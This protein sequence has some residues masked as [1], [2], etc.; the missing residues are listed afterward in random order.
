MNATPHVAQNTNG[1]VGDRRPHHAARGLCRE[2]THP[3]TDR[4]GLRLD[5]DHRR[6]GTDQ[7]PAAASASD[8]PSPSPPPLTIWPGCRSSWRRWREGPGKLPP[9]RPLADRRGRHLGPGSPRSLRPGGAD[10]HRARRR[11]RLRRLGGRPRSRIRPRLD[12]LS[13]GRL[14]RK[15][16]RSMAKEPPNFSTTAPSRS[17]SNTETATKPSS[18]R[19]G[20][21]LQ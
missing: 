16:T 17:N 20:T 21:L 5:Q 2:P 13:L 4:G 10:N 19:N 18:K 14:A 1:V 11:N 3:Q 9:D 7:V 15:A 12:R 6:P 8:G